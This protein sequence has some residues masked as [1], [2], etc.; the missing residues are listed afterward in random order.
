M[1]FLPPADATEAELQTTFEKEI[2][3][4]GY[5]PNYARVFAHRP[6]V[7]NG[8][9]TLQG[10]IRS[11]FDARLYE[12]ATLA[13]SRTLTSTYCSLAHA[14]ALVDRFYSKEDVLRIVTTPEESALTPGEVLLMEFAAKVARDA[15]SVQPADVEALS[16]SGFT[17]V[18]IFGIAATAAARSFFAKLLDALGAEPDAALTG[19]GPELVA[20]LTVGRPIA[21]GG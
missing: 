9:R 1:P 10:A 20:E 6:E 21:A 17:P 12:L 19:L 4:W 11:G 18:E 15:T 13:A 16:K 5:L 14:K 7:L 8:F 2:A 3:F